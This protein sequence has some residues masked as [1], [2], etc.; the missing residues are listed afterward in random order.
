MYTS[1]E[2]L[3]EWLSTPM[4]GRIEFKEAKNTYGAEKLMQYCVA[5]AN[6]GGGKFI[7]GVTNL[8]PRKIVGTHAFENTEGIQS[9][10]FERLK[11]RVDVEE[12]QHRDGRVVIF[13][14][15]SRPRGLPYAYNGQHWMRVGEELHIMSQ[16]QLRAIFDEGKPDWLSE[17]A[18]MNV[19]DQEILRLLDI[20]TYFRLTKQPQV[21]DNILQILERE[22]LIEKVGKN[23]SITN[24]GAILFAKKLDPFEGVKRKAVRVIVYEGTDKPSK[25]I[26]DITGNMGYAVGFERLINFIS[27]YLPKN[28]VIGK[29]LRETVP[30]YPDI[31]IRELVANAIIHQDLNETGTSV[32]IEIYADRVEISNPGIPSISPE[33]F[34]DEFQSRNERLANLMRRLRICEETGRGIDYVIKSVEAFQL[35]APDFR[36]GERRTM[37]ILFGH[38]EID[39][40]DGGDRI[41]A[42]YQHCV[43]KFV[44]EERMTNQSL[45]ERF[46]LP[47]SKSDLISRIIHEAVDAK[48]V[49]LANPESASKRYSQ[50]VPY[51][52]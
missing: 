19:A 51:W 32:I 38:K 10:I 44:M 3:N 15:P 1:L 45:R 16:D 11:F 34:I 50:Y 31:A 9:T 29:A 6:E 37:A 39:E 36:A 41:R 14:V 2:E 28:E 46:K 26:T 27:N 8:I 4:E 23:F 48:L 13:H 52:A 20:D 47:E 35:P 22:R 7:L 43:L 40:M 21:Q 42:C 49:R 30:M 18:L 5:I 17:F 33:H 12:R 25:R 24:L